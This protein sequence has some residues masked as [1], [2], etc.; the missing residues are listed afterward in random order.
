METTIKQVSPVEYELEISAAADD[1]SPQINDALRAQRGQTQMKGFRP[2]KVPI[3]LVKKMHGK[4]IAY[5]VAEETVQKT[6][7]SEVLDSDEYKVLGQPTLTEL[8][9][10]MDG[11][12]RATVRF[13]VRPD[14][15][16]KDLSG[17]RVPKLL[18]EVTDEEIEEE[19]ERIRRREA[20]LVPA[21]EG[22]A[23]EDHVV[24]DLQQLDEASGSP[25]I[26]N[27]EEN[28]TFFLDDE[29]LH[30]EL[31]DGLLGKKDGETF[32]V[33]LPHGH[34]DHVH[35]HLYEV[36]VKEV[37]SRELPDLDDEFINETTEGEHETVE[38]F[39][40][41]VRERMQKLWDQ[42]SRELLENEMVNRLLELHTVPVPQAAVE[43]YLDS[44]VEDVKR[45]NEGKFPEGFDAATFRERN[46]GEA[47][48]Q[49]QWMLIRDAVIEQEGV[50]VTDE[51]LNEHFEEVAG[52]DDRITPEMMR[53][54][55]QSVG[56]LDQVRQQKLSEKVFS[57]LANLF[58]VEELDRDTY[59]SE[60]ET[61]REAALA[62][63]E[64]FMTEAEAAEKES[65]VKV[66]PELEAPSEAPEEP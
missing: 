36:T 50:E 34:G 37:K 59:E 64:T 44:F 65:T 4:A 35:T 7:Q 2:G 58:E 40:Q 23:P 26:G 46:R 33:H 18:H 29:K 10:E 22:A 38:S 47:E 57:A 27:R 25:I 32:R 45:R 1:L 9:Y 31:R 55:Y 61:R 13:G 20:D 19:L 42:R 43:M 16:L 66:D 5:T 24:I 62:Q 28:V 39:R 15:E 54:Y 52:G 12:L 48:K 3:S 17:E 41:A 6:F 53:Q 49:A 8:E 30:D 60:M 14:V 63:A 56:A 21:E 11:D 51:D